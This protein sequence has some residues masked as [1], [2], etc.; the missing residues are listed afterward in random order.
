[1]RQFFRRIGAGFLAPSFAFYKPRPSQ[2]NEDE[3]TRK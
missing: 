1:M 3:D 2:Q